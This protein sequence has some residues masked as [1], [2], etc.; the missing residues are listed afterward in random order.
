MKKVE[1]ED[2]A[3]KPVEAPQPKP[4]APIE[5]QKSVEPVTAPKPRPTW[6]SI[7]KEIDDFNTILAR[8]ESKLPTVIPGFKEVYESMPDIN[9]DHIPFERKVANTHSY[10]VQNIEKRES[11]ISRIKKVK[12]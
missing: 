9:M 3:P 2:I 8:L 5:E 6:D 4:P 11:L 10:F 1:S 7:K 12:Q